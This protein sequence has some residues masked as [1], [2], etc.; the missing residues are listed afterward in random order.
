MYPDEKLL[1]HPGHQE[2]HL[3]WKTLQLMIISCLMITLK[4]TTFL[5]YYQGCCERQIDCYSPKISEA[6]EFLTSLYVY[7]KNLSYSTLNTAHAVLSPP[8]PKDWDYFG[9]LPLT[10]CFMIGL[11]ENRAPYPRYREIHVWNA[12]TVLKYLATL[13]P[14]EQL[15]LKHPI[16]KL[17]MLLLLDTGQRGQSIHLLNILML[18]TAQIRHSHFNL[19]CTSHTK[20]NKPRCPGS[21]IVIQELKLD[22]QLLYAHCIH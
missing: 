1:Q 13:T 2:P 7:D 17:I 5:D 12:L 15:S 3:L 9:L 10:V 16:L 21:P 22:L 6:F 18:W 4:N 20:T 8:F 11:F 19:H 14:L